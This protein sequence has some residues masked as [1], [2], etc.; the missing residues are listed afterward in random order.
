M[1]DIYTELERLRKQFQLA[2]QELQELKDEKN[3][4]Y[5]TAGR[6][7]KEPESLDVLLAPLGGLKDV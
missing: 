1:R 4:K 3:L 6:L 7:S 2:Q 5:L